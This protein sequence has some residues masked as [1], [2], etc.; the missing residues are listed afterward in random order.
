MHA[1]EYLGMERSAC[2]YT[3]RARH[4]HALQYSRSRILILLLQAQDR[5]LK[6]LLA[7][8]RHINVVAHCSPAPLIVVRRR[9]G[10]P[11]IIWQPSHGS[12]MPTS[13]MHGHFHQCARESTFREMLHAVADGAEKRGIICSHASV[14]KGR[15]GGTRRSMPG[16]C[17]GPIDDERSPSRRRQQARSARARPSHRERVRPRGT[18]TRAHRAV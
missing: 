13:T 17:R 11:A 10:R 9:A 12:W 15:N 18:F 6:P 16:A 2:S 3:A 7:P 8:I 4:V 5:I 1:Y 14:R